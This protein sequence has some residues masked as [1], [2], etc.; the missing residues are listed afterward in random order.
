[1]EIQQEVSDTDLGFYGEYIN[2]D[3]NDSSNNTYYA[4]LLRDAPNGKWI[5]FENSSTS[6]DS[7]TT[8]SEDNY[9]GLNMGSLRI[10]KSGSGTATG[11]LHVGTNA[12]G[13]MFP[14]NRGQTDKYWQLI[15]LVILTG[16]TME[17]EV[18]LHFKFRMEEY[19]IYFMFL[20]FL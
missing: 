12:A 18:H 10:M 14:A 16:S 2:I 3:G 9:A 5:L 20:I 15:M 6:G 17:V 7:N 4:G 13:Y 19:Q 1:M 8:I 11:V